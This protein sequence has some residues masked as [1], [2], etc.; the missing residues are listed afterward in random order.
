M[1]AWYGS[2]NTDNYPTYNS[3]GNFGGTRTFQ[4]MAGNGTSYASQGMAIISIPHN[5]AWPRA[6]V[7]GDSQ[8]IFRSADTTHYME[9]FT[10]SLSVTNP[11]TTVTGVHVYGSGGNSEY[12]SVE[13]FGIERG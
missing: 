12:G 5:G 3:G 2:T 13:I 8:L 4:W 11:H 9:Q 6:S 1:A 10:G 7:R